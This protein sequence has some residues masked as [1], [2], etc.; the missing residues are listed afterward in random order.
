[1]WSNRSARPGVRPRVD[2]SEPRVLGGRNDCGKEDHF[3]AI[4]WQ[5]P[6]VAALVPTE[7]NLDEDRGPP[8]LFS[9][10][11]IQPR[12]L[13][14]STRRGYLSTHPDGWSAG[15]NETLSAIGL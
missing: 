11:S 10:A 12:L 13:S 6:V 15:G 8:E 7:E 3:P 1:M 5:A 9:C 2:P 4:V 14:C